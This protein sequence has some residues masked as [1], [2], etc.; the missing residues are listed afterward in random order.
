MKNKPYLKIKD[1]GQLPNLS[2][3]QTGTRGPEGPNGFSLDV[4]REK[5][6]LIYQE[7]YKRQS[8]KGDLSFEE[9]E[10]EPA[11]TMKHVTDVGIFSDAELRQFIVDA[12]AKYS[13][14]LI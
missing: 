14:R 1:A 6:A 4:L 11:N 3:G 5:L 7:A 9:I 10:N 8:R 12:E 13:I 2:Q